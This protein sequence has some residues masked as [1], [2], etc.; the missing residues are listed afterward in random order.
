MVYIRRMKFITT[1]AIKEKI[2]VR[3]NHLINHHILSSYCCLSSGTSAFEPFEH[4]LFFDR[5]E[6][7]FQ[8]I[9]VLDGLKNELFH[10]VIESFEASN[11]FVDDSVCISCIFAFI[12]SKKNFAILRQV[13]LRENYF[14]SWSSLGAISSARNLNCFLQS[15][16]VFAVD[17]NQY[18]GTHFQLEVDSTPVID[19]HHV[20]A[21]VLLCNRVELEF[22]LLFILNILEADFEFS[23]DL[24]SLVA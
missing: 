6:A 8:Q 9:L 20:K 1:S 12:S 13:R 24:C 7:D 15:K 17:D 5:F 2:Q 23:T 19:A 14:R 4:L 10:A 21:L 16:F 11:D 22:Q 3:V 18:F